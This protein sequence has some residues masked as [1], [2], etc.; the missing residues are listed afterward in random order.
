MYL[1]G[2]YLWLLIPGLILG[3]YAQEFHAQRAI[4]L[5]RA[6]VGLPARQGQPQIVP[7]KSGGYFNA[8]L[9]G[10]TE[11]DADA[12]CR[13]LRGGGAFCVRLSPQELNDPVAIWRN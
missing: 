6:S 3:I 10:L 2:P 4:E 11:K 8:L 1:F 7:L 12:T 5:A 9:V 13:S